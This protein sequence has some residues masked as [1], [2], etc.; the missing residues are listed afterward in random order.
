MLDAMGLPKQVLDSL[1][2]Q[3]LLLQEAER[4]HLNAT[5]EEV[6]RKILEIPVLNP[7][8][9]FVGNELYTRY[10]TGQ[11]GY[12]TASEFEDELAREITLQKMESALA[13]SVIV[14]PKMADAEFRRISE[15]AKIRYVLY[16]ASREVASVNVT[17]AEVDA[18]YK[19]NQTKYS[20]GEQRDVK[21]LIADFNRLRSQLDAPLRHDRSNGIRRAIIARRARAT[22]RSTRVRR[23]RSRRT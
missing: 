4:L 20:H 16:P 11:M 7:D 1:I 17:P 21:Y 8:G 23:G 15:N 3:R 10:V 5:S 18:F 13:S 6:R 22:S 9:K 19:A 12:Q 14:S 2:D